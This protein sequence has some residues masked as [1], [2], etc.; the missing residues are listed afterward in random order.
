MREVPATI[1]G[2]S[3]HSVASICAV[4][5]GEGVYGIDTREV[6][7]VLGESQIRQVPLAPWF[8]AGVMPYRGEVLAAVSLR[9]VLGLEPSAERTCVLVLEDDDRGRHFGLIVDAVGGVVAVPEEGLQSNPTTLDARRSAL[10]AG[11]WQTETGLLVKL[12]PA[13]LRPSRLAAGG[14]NGSNTSMERLE[15]RCER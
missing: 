10:F 11:V 15:A 2:I 8:I 3:K 14:L 9:A 5:T 6:R 4:T 1:Q 12:E 13:R 7:E